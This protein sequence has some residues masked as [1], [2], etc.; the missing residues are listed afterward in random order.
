VSAHRQLAKA[1]PL[2]LAYAPV[3]RS[4]DFGSTTATTQRS[5]DDEAQTWTFTFGVGWLYGIGLCIGPFFGTGVGLTFP[6]GVLAGAGGGVGVVVGI[7]AG[8]GIIW[9]S[10]RGIMKGVGS[11]PPMQP[12]R[13]SELPSPPELARRAA[14]FVDTARAQA[15]RI[16]KEMMRRPP[17]TR[18]GA[19]AFVPPPKLALRTSFSSSRHKTVLR[20]QHLLVDPRWEAASYTR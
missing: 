19:G 7:G 20:A 18:G 5:E 17:K 4:G 8:S 3:G 13:L 10:G 11:V 9:G 1:R 16:T 14:D 15:S 2:P 12:P 6:G